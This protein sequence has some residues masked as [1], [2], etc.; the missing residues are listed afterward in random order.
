ME[1]INSHFAHS[2]THIDKECLQTTY[3]QQHF[4]LNLFPV[5]N[6]E[7]QT[8]LSSASWPALPARN[9]K[10][11]APELRLRICGA[12]VEPAASQHP[13]L[14]GL[15]PSSSSATGHGLTDAAAASAQL[16]R[17]IS[18]YCK[19]SFSSFFSLARRAF[20]LRA[21]DCSCKAFS[22][23]FSVFLAWMASISTRLFL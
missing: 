16:S 11:R 17:T 6:T 23:I 18:I 20:S 3:K 21:S 7:L 1:K 9:R 8:K 5:T 15:H 22:F 2:P 14:F 13:P 10:E 4:F 19:A 12:C